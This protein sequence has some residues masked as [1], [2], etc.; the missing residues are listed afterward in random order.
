MLYEHICGPAG[1]TGRESFFFG[2]EY[3]QGVFFCRQGVPAGSIFV[4]A[5]STG[6][7]YFCSGRE[8]RQGVLFSGREYRQGAQYSLPE[9]VLP[10]GKKSLCVVDFE[11]SPLYASFHSNVNVISS[12]FHPFSDPRSHFSPPRG[13]RLTKNWFYMR[14]THVFIIYFGFQKSKNF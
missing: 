3:R 12:R 2:R 4:P 13:A 6:R 9:K 11:Y 5:G 14:H 7:E 1:S 10:V 8:Y